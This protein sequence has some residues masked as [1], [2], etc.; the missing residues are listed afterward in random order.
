MR[1]HRLVYWLYAGLAR[2]SD[3]VLQNYRVTCNIETMNNRE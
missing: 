3:I 2:I 1:I